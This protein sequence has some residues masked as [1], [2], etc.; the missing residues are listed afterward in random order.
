MALPCL[1]DRPGPITIIVAVSPTPVKF[2]QN[3]NDARK[4]VHVLLSGRRRC[5]ARFF[6]VQVLVDF[7]SI[8]SPSPGYSISSS[9]YTGNNGA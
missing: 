7:R 4:D 5:N 6:L 1:I 3:V 2:T 9:R 8:S